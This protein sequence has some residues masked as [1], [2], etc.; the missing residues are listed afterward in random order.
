MG[1]ESVNAC[2]EHEGETLK[3]K[4]GLL[5]LEYEIG[6]EPLPTSFMG[7]EFTDGCDWHS[8]GVSLCQTKVCLHLH[9]P[10]PA[11]LHDAF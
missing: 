5:D 3:I 6:G 7:F 2:S 11:C 4:A 10:A 1:S 9:V 8:D